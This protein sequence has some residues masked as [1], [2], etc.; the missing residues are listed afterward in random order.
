MRLR[1]S[2]VLRHLRHIPT[3]AG[4]KLE[5]I[6]AT[7][8]FF[9]RRILRIVGPIYRRLVMKVSRVHC[10][11]EEVATRIFA[12]GRGSGTT[13]LV[14]FRH[15]S[16]D[17]PLLVYSLLDRLIRKAGGSPL[18]GPVF[19]YGRDVPVWA[20]SPAEWL[21]PRTGAICVFHEQVKRDSLDEVYAAIES[22]EAPVALAPEA[23]VT[24]HNYRV[25]PSQTGTAHLAV[26]GAV[27]K[28]KTVSILPLGLEYRYPDRGHRTFRKLLDSILR[29]V[30]LPP[31]GAATD[32][33]RLPELLWRGA[34]AVLEAVAAAYHLPDGGGPLNADSL[35]RTVRSII[36][37]ALREGETA[38]GLPIEVDRDPIS[39]VFRLRRAYWE[40]LFPGIE[41]APLSQKLKDLR[42]TE[43]RITARYFQTVDLLAYLDFTYLT[44]V[45][46][47]PDA[48]MPAA[49]SDRHARLVEYLVAIHDLTNRAMGHTIGQRFAW[50][51]RWCS[52]RF[53]EPI[54]VTPPTEA[55]TG[56]N[57][58]DQTRQL[59]HEIE[60]ALRKVSTPFH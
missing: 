30:G 26:W 11:N 37:A 48:P 42:A 23:Q 4:P 49:G 28:G 58:T 51:G 24:Y 12:G 33:D 46:L 36:A 40:R 3:L 6:P 21:L 52:A 55:I 41:S 25:A 31:T 34:G 56:S 19:L 9:I 43:G 14:A 22:G 35:N 17:D 53:D 1:R 20:G 2:S 47:G 29:A 27:T 8:S 44:E 54:V 57:R 45:G 38:A 5:S 10:R 59:H 15:P 60:E 7:P 18:H 39:R 32:P 50:R 13:V 16:P